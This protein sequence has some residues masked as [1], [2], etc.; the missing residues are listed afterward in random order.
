MREIPKKS[1]KKITQFL[2]RNFFIIT[3]HILFSI[4]IEDIFEF[5]KYTKPSSSQSTAPLENIKYPMAPLLYNIFNDDIFG[6]GV[7]DE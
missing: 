7:N 1:N 4:H 3:E 5:H 2:L 6:G